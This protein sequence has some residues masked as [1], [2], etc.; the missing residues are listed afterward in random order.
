[1]AIAGPTGSD[2]NTE[3]EVKASPGSKSEAKGKV[4]EGPMAIAGPTG[5]DSNAEDAVMRTP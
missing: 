4:K 5:S 1:M 3:E 2:S